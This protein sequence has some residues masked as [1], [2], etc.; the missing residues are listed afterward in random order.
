MEH[1][2]PNRFEIE[3]L[4]FLRQVGQWISVAMEKLTQQTR[5]VLE[6]K[7]TEQ[8]EGLLA[9][10]LLH[11][12]RNPLNNLALAAQV[13][14]Q[15]AGRDLEDLRANVSRISR[16]VDDFLRQRDR[17]GQG[18]E[19][20]PVDLRAALDEA[21]ARFRAYN[22]TSDV[23]VAY[24][25]D[26]SLPTIHAKREMLVTAFVNL[27][28]NGAVATGDT[29]RLLVLAHYSP[30]RGRVEIVFSDDGPGILP[31]DVYRIF[32]YGYTTGGDDHFG[33]GLPLTKEVVQLHGGEITVEGSRSGASFT[34]TLPVRPSAFPTPGSPEEHTELR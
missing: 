12:L 16:V 18:G 19:W 20:E 4:R 13:E 28:K 21:L 3:D 15:I 11:E 25:V 2:A 8:H 32:D 1:E 7:R 17:S 30:L 34:L 26:S 10:A 29:G 31:Q 5:A 33:Y 24:N 6:R 9:R 14:T 22:P 23:V 27:L